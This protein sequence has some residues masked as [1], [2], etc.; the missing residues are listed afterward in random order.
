MRDAV[1][2]DALDL[3]E[4]GRNFAVFYELCWLTP[5]ELR[6]VRA[7]ALQI[8]RIADDRRPRPDGKLFGV[9]FVV[10][11]VTRRARRKGGVR[12]ADGG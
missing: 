6:Q 7:L 5:D 2:A 9:H 4:A 12:A 1:A 3:G 10:T 8:K 11:P